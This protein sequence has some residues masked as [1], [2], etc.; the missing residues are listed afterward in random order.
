[1]LDSEIYN[2]LNLRHNRY[3]DKW[4]NN[5]PYYIRDLISVRYSIKIILDVVKYWQR[6]IQYKWKELNH[7]LFSIICSDDMLLYWKFLNFNKVKC[8]P[9]LLKCYYFYHYGLNLDQLIISVIMTALFHWFTKV[10]L[11][12]VVGDLCWLFLTF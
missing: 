3:S 12:E 8:D 5:N 2:S 1:M 6:R 9:I 10:W 7:I 11:I 4:K